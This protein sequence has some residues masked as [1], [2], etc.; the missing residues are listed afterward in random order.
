MSYKTYLIPALFFLA[1][2]A[3][4]GFSAPER[5]S[6]PV[7]KTYDPRTVSRSI[8]RVTNQEGTSGG[9]GFAVR[10]PSDTVIIVTNDHVCNVAES[11]RVYV[12]DSVTTAMGKIVKRDFEHDLCAVDIG[13]LAPAPLPIAE[14]ELTRFDAVYVVGHPLLMPQ[15]PVAGQVIDRTIETIGFR[16]SADGT[17]PKPSTARESLFGSV[18]VLNMELMTTTL[19]TFPGNSGS[20]VLNADGDV[21]GVI[22]SGDTR[23]GWG[24]YIQLTHLRGFLRGL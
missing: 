3:S 22:N 19:P 7:I 13:P 17:C 15:T 14:R 11:D 20:P 8:L 5:V 23:T 4:F 12:R 18:C 1:I 24:G 21:A 9:T 6:E 16:P 2:L 10:A